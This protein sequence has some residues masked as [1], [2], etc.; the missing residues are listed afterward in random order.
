MDAPGTCLTPSPGDSRS[1]LNCEL[2]GKRR[3]LP[4]CPKSALKGGQVV[5]P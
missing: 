5:Q 3:R 4:A 2:T 1:K